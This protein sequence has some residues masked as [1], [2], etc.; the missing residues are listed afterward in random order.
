[1]ATQND[2]TIE[3]LARTICACVR[4]EVP[5]DAVHNHVEKIVKTA[6]TKAATFLREDTGDGAGPA[7]ERYDEIRSTAWILNRMLDEFP[8]RLLH[9]PSY[10]LDPETME[11]LCRA[12]AALSAAGKLISK[13][14]IREGDRGGN[15]Q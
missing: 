3:E 11:G 14:S 12:S 13:V 2:S 6:E 4:Y 9:D 10:E 1:M 5:D 7:K 15:A 8:A